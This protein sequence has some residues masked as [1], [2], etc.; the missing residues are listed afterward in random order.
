[1]TEEEFNKRL[2]ELGVTAERFDSVTKGRC[3]RFRHPLM[4]I[5]EAVSYS[6]EAIDDLKE[7]HGIDGNATAREETLKQLEERFD[8]FAVRLIATGDADAF[9]K[10]FNFD[11]L[12]TLANKF[13]EVAKVVANPKWKSR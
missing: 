10:H 6:Q 9:F 8:V 11:F 12:E 2:E 4:G 3:V 5:I 7:T 13:P 1:M